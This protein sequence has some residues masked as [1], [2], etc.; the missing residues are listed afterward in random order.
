MFLECV[1]AGDD[2]RGDEGTVVSSVFSYGSAGG[3]WGDQLGAGG[4][5]GE[6]CGGVSWA[7]D[8]EK[9]GKRQRR[10]AESAESEQRRGNCGASCA[11]FALGGWAEV[12]VLRLSPVNTTG[13]P[14][15][16]L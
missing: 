10:D 14:T 7:V 5:C 13:V 15:P 4:D 16:D 6:E 3:G 11:R 9:E 1:A 12:E 8:T 2:D